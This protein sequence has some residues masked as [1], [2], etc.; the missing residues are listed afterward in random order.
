[1]LLLRCPL[2]IVFLVGSGGAKQR[3]L[4]GAD[5]KDR[6]RRLRWLRKLRV[7]FS[8]KKP[9]SASRIG[10]GIKLECEPRLTCGARSV[11]V[12]AGDPPQHFACRDSLFRL[13]AAQEDTWQQAPLACV[14]AGGR[15]GRIDVELRALF[16]GRLQQRVDQRKNDGATALSL[17][18]FAAGDAMQRLHDGLPAAGQTVTTTAALTFTSPPLPHSLIHCVHNVPR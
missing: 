4:E 7:I 1:M 13:R 16:T 18:P 12:L 17:P 10:H 5:R 11:A 8:D 3:T 15:R 6:G 14:E 2:I 9:V